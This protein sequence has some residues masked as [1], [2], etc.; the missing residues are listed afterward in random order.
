ML[1]GLI[2]AG[3]QTQSAVLFTPVQK[4]LYPGVL[5]QLENV[6]KYTSP[7]RIGA[8]GQLYTEMDLT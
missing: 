2:H 4:T 3:P 7:F 6:G 1:S 5:G 8:I